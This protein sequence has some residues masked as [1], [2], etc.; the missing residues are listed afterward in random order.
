MI[1]I[2]ILIPFFYRPHIGERLYLLSWPLL[3][4]ISGSEHYFRAFRFYVNNIRNDLSCQYIWVNDS[5]NYW[6]SFENILLADYKCGN[7]SH[8][9]TL[10]YTFSTS[11]KG[12]V[13]NRLSFEWFRLSPRTNS[14]PSGTVNWQ[15]CSP[16]SSS[17]KYGSS[18]FSP[19]T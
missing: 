12:L 17:A 3:S 13:H 7:W 14:F 4:R 16:L 10:A 1:N 18:S 5:N 6:G 11:T 19:L 8:I 2:Y 9:S 15:S